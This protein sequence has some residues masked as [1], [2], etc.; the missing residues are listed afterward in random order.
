MEAKWIAGVLIC[1][2]LGLA[3][4]FIVGN[5]MASVSC[6]SKINVLETT[7]NELKNDLGDLQWKYSTLKGGYDRLKQE[8]DDLNRTYNWLKMQNRSCYIEE[9]DVNITYRIEGNVKWGV[10]V[11]G[12]VKNVGDKPIKKLYVCAII[13][14]A[15][16]TIAS[17]PYNCEEIRDLYMGESAPFSLLILPAPGTENGTVKIFIIR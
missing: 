12:N 3:I 7:V 8:Y 14:T 13:R 11:I 17:Y 16:G 5:Y 15:D 9:S 10:K 4:G 6:S 2:I 1:C